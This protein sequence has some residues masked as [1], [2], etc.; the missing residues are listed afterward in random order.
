MGIVISFVV[1]VVVGS[2]GLFAIQNGIAKQLK[3][4]I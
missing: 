2:L 1:G 3:D 4:K